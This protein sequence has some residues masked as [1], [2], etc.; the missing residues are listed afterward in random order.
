MLRLKAHLKGL[1][2]SEYISIYTESGTPTKR[3]IYG[4][5]PYVF[6]VP[7][8]PYFSYYPETKERS[9]RVYKP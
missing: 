8:F 5:C 4:V 6:Y 2:I 1:E 9:G 3:R 7:V